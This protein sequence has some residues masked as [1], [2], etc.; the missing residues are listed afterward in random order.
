MIERYMKSKPTDL[1]IRINELNR[2]KDIIDYELAAI[3]CVISKHNGQ[4]YIQKVNKAKEMS[5]HANVPKQIKQ[6]K[7]DHNPSD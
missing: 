5:K 2:R 6:N 3:R 1:Q 4:A 7:T